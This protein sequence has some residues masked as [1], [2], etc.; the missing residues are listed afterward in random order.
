[1]KKL[2]LLFI[3]A[4]GLLNAAIAYVQGA[5]GTGTSSPLA[6]ALP[7]DATAGNLIVVN[8]KAFTATI[9]SITDSRSNTYTLAVTHTYWW[10]QSIYYAKNIVGGSNTITIAFTGDTVLAASHEY[11]GLDTTSPL[12]KTSSAEGGS[13][14]GDSGAQTTTVADELIF[15]A[16]SSGAYMNGLAG[17]GFTQRK[18]IDYGGGCISEEKI[19][20]ST[21]SYSASFLDSG[22]S[23]MAAMAT[24]KGA[25]AAARR[26]VVIVQ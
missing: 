1:M 22:S 2:I 20:S 15:G 19:V 12:D 10:T 5:E 7:G 24:F 13:G 4:C 6:Y 23:W 3:F 14:A 11:S 18:V 21:G 25:S 9:T 8:I 26:R 17:S 16:A